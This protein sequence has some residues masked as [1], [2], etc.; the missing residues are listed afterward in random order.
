M[1]QTE[2][3]EMEMVR[4]DIENNYNETIVIKQKELRKLMTKAKKA[5][6]YT[7]PADPVIIQYPVKKKGVY[8][9]KKVTD[10]SKLLVRPRKS[11]V[12]IAQCPQAKVRPTG[13]NRCRND[14]SDIALEVEGVPPLSV[15]YRLFV[16]DKPRGGSEFESLQADDTV[17]PLSRHTSQ[18][19]VKSG[20]EDVSWARSVKITVPLNET[21]ATGT[22]WAY[23]IE[24]VRDGL[25][26]YVNYEIVED[27]DR[28]RVK[29]ADLSQS[30]IV[31][32]RPKVNLKECNPQNPLQV[33]KGESAHLPIHYSSTGK[34]A[35]NSAHAIEYLFTPEENIVADGYQSPD[36]QL[37]K[38]TLKNIHEQPLISTAGLYTLKSISTDFCTGEILEPTSCLLQNPPQP[39][40]VLSSE[41]IVDKCAGNP[42]G[43][44]VALDFTGTPP[45]HLTYT[46]QK[47]GYKP[48]TRHQQVASLR[49]SVD[50]TPSEAGHYTYTFKEVSDAVYR[51]HVLNNLV[52]QQDV[53]P[54]AS[55]HFIEGNRPKQACIDQTAEFD[56][57]LI[58][59]GPFRLEYEIVHNGRRTKKSVDVEDSHY[60]IKTDSLKSGG[61]YTVALS[62]ITD[63]MNC[64]DFLKDEAKV[65]VR[66]ERPKAYFGHIEGKQFV[67]GLEGRKVDLPIRLTGA[68]PWHLEYE[69]LDTNSKE[70]TTISSANSFLGVTEQ[71]SYQ[72]QSVRDS[73]CPGF[74]EEKA[75]QF[76]VSWIARPQ[77]SIAESPS[78]V[79]ENNKYIKDAVCEG[80]EDSFDV[81]FTGKF[82][83]IVY[84]LVAT[85]QSR[86][87][88]IRLL[89]QTRVQGPEGQDYLCQP[90]GR[91]SNHWLCID[92]CRYR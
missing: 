42:I 18:A 75:S 40:L 2:P 88:S 78:I 77:M 31:H 68:G 79:F 24:E 64:K 73:V 7:D 12:V 47:K 70:Q 32:E 36:A 15:K 14:L 35:I 52:L 3:V 48:K 86:K 38:Q 22:K 71:G 45:F 59:E 8:L 60:V 5:T 49:G 87:C 81:A 82:I 63:K 62:S 10:Q 37:K 6:K 90:E 46:E 74:I 85:D 23:S 43:L 44:R 25:G 55:A 56:V 1:N 30:F 28:P 13:A 34:R 19:L 76:D 51:G 16:D 72:L 61:E 29:V 26:N 91:E 80:D 58:G 89:L 50:L 66:H 65:Q 17:S 83:C 84:C 9:L 33:A 57:R 4:I 11:N 54:P 20:D 21:L 92:S 39:D 69:N 41:D 27:E 53:K 67:M